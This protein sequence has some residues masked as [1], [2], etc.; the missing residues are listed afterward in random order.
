MHAVPTWLTV[1]FATFLLAFGAYRIWYATRPMPH[2]PD[3]AAP[4]SLL[5]GGMSRIGKRTHLLIGIVYVI[6]ALLLVAMSFGW[7]P[8]SRSMSPD[9]EEPSRDN[10]PVKPNSVPIDRPPG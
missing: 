6:G 2:D 4:R 9:T 10:A 1:G 3:A 7:S 8:V 5:G